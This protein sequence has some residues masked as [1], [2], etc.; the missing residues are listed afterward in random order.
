MVIIQEHVDRPEGETADCEQ[1]NDRSIFSGR[2]EDDDDG[3]LGYDE[4]GR[5]LKL[6]SWRP[7]DPAKLSPQQ[8]TA[9]QELFRRGDI[10]WFLHP[11]QSRLCE[12]LDAKYRELAVICISR[13]FG[14][15][16]FCLAYAI[17]YCLANPRSTVLYI[18]PTK[19]QLGKFMTSKIQTVFAFLPDDCVPEQRGS[20]WQ[21][22]NGS[23]FRLDGISI[24]GGA[25]VRGDTVDLVILDECRDM[26]DLQTMIESHVSPMFT[27]TDGRLIMISTPPDSPLHAFTEKY[28]KE[29][30]ISGNFYSATYRQNPLL[31]T[32][33]LRYLIDTQFPGGEENI[34]FRREYMADYRVADLSKRVVREWDEKANDLFFDNYSGP[35]N[36]VRPY[37]LMDYAHNDPAG[38]L[39]GYYDSLQGCLI[40]EREWFKRGMNTDEVGAKIVE[41]EKELADRLPGAVEPIRVM[42]CDPSLSSDLFCR[43]NLR[44][45]PAFKVPNSVAMLNRLRVAFTTNKVKIRRECPD[46]RFQLS[47]GVYNAK[48]TDYI[49]TARGGH[50]DLLDAL[51]Y[52]VLNMRWNELLRT[53]D[54]RKGLLWNEMD[55]RRSPFG[56]GTFRSGMFQRP[57]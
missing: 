25:R 17:A 1:E 44:F 15:S 5:S 30:Q 12:W 35:P 9:C 31:T 3:E 56:H 49:R 4:F 23:I 19:V 38:I 41:M 28:I 6:L 36:P 43:F 57:V 11:E 2:I 32:K 50:L 13:Q 29:S 37:T 42:D 14:K 8:R 20:H 47:A 46:L 53:E 51:K 10:S 52:G 7:L 45:E 48:G 54:V 40:I 21:F 26:A 16:I 18:A 34:V 39:V 24:G 22:P 33:R 27:A 55:T